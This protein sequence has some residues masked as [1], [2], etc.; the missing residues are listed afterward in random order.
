M[1]LKLI[2]LLT[3]VLFCGACGGST[4]TGEPEVTDTPQK[5][6]REPQNDLERKLDYVRTGRFRYTLV[7]SRRDGGT[8]DKEAIDFLKTNSPRDVNQW[9]ATDDKKYAI[10]GTNF[11]FT[12]EN[13]IALQKRFN[14]ED[15]TGVTEGST[16][17]PVSNSNI[18]GNAAN[19]NA[20]K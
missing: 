1:K 17:A 10:A 15:F 12:P 11:A 19:S 4:S 8:F 7:F 13:L 2:F 20:A 3:L 18:S 5:P 16:G 14:I 9:V 6:K